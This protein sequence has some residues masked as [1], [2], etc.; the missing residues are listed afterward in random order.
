MNNQPCA[1][2]HTWTHQFGDDWTPEIGTPCD[3]R[4]KQWG[5]PL[6]QAREH[7]WQLY[8]NDTFC[9]RCGAAIGAGEQ[10]R[11]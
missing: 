7:D 11:S 5:L 4:Q 3:C 10:C 9:R 1:D 8:G 2:G 6:Q